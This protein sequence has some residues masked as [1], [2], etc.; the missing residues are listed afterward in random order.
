L[1]AAADNNPLAVE[2]ETENDMAFE[3]YYL[4]SLF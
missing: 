3:D 4:A 1:P 2:T